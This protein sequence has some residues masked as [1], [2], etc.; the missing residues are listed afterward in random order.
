MKLKRILSSALICLAF[1]CLAILPF[2]V[3]ADAKIALGAKMENFSLPDADGKQQSFDHLKGKNGT[4]VVFLSVQ[5][6]VVNKF[7]AARLTQMG[8]DLSA[9]GVNV[10]GV[11]SNSTETA[12]QVKANITERSYSYPVLIDKGNVIADKLNASVTPEVFLFDKD[13]KL[14]YRGAIDNDRTGEKITENYLRDAVDLAVAGKAIAKAETIGFGC[15]IKRA[16]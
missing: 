14:V 16:K 10:I 7:Y 1:T 6:P 12:E 11:N 13:G 15:S 5:C 8:K 3:N 2:A 4:V 9:K